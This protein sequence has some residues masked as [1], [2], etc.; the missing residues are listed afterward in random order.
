M[1]TFYVIALVSRSLVDDIAKREPTA[2]DALLN[3]VN[4]QAEKLVTRF[5]I[6]PEPKR[7]SDRATARHLRLQPGQPLPSVVAFKF[8]GY[9]R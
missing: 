8:K 9:V 2:M 6:D 7:L 3:M 4:N 1:K 5:E